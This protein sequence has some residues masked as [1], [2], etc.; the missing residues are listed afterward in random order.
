M[1]GYTAEAVRAINAKVNE[2]LSRYD[3]RDKNWVIDPSVNIDKIADGCGVS[4]V[5]FVSP[6]QLNGVHADLKDGIVRIDESDT[7]GQRVFD[8]AHEVGHIV[9]NQLNMNMS[10]NIKI[11]Q[12]GTG[13]KSISPIVTATVEYKA[14]RHGIRGKAELTPWERE[15]E[16]F[17]DR[18][19]ANILVPINRFNLWESKTDKV[20]ADVFKVEEKCIKKRRE[21]VEYEVKVLTG[22]MKPCSIEAITDS[23]VELDIDAMLREI[24]SGN[25]KR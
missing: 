12:P 22:K 14:A 4:K 24:N 2:L 11:V 13:S 9:F 10:F 16:D 3:D 1:Q 23:D 19:A 17:F 6:E 18:F 5:L 8:L 15:I 7:A 20:I 25:V 21:E